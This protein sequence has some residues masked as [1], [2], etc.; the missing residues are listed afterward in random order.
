MMKIY[1]NNHVKLYM[2]LIFCHVEKNP[3]L[4]RGKEVKKEGWCIYY[5]NWSI[6]IQLWKTWRKVKWDLR[7]DK[8]NDFYCKVYYK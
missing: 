8:M 3:G 5:T 1:L 4:K 2:V 6:S 7:E